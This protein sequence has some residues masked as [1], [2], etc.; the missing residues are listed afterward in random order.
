MADAWGRK[1]VVIGAIA[2]FC[3]ASLLRRSRTR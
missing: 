1:R 2:I 3:T